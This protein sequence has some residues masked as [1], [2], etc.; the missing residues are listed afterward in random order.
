[1]TQISPR[2]AQDIAVHFERMTT[3]KTQQRRAARLRSL[4][5]VAAMLATAAL[6]GWS[7]AATQAT[8]QALPALVAQSQACAAW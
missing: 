3:R 6:T 7:L 5:L 4:T 8:V 1:M 2:H